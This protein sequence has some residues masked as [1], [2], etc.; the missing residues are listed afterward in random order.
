MAVTSDLC[1]D[2]K[3]GKVEEDEPVF[4]STSLSYE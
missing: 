3:I 2:P 1:M 4:N